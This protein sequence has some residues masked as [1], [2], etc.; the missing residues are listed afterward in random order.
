MND[1]DPLQ[2]VIVGRCDNS[3]IPPEEAATSE[4]ARRFRDARHGGLRPLRPS[5]AA[6]WR[7]RNL[8]EIL[9]SRGVVV[10]RPTPLQWNQAI[11]TPDFRN[12]P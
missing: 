1:W 4:G 2:R 10:D 6:I 7:P 9:E 8:V 12:D 5:S 3:V 11:G